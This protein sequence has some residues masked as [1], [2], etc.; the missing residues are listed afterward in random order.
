[1][2]ETAEY[3]LQTPCPASRQCAFP[4]C[5]EFLIL[6]FTQI[7]RIEQRDLSN[8]LQP[9]IT[10][11]LKFAMLRACLIGLPYIHA[12]CLDPAPL[13]VG[14]GF[15][16]LIGSFSRTVRGH[17]Q[18]TRLIDVCHHAHV[19]L[20]CAEA[21]LIDHGEGLKQQSEAGVFLRRGN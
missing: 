17:F 1:M 6:L 15:S 13:L 19:I 7:F 16:R 11:L 18:N 12:D 4:Q 5:S 20:T 8:A 21:L 10:A 3:F 2:P 9:I 14:E